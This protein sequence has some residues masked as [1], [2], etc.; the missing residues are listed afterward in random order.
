MILPSVQIFSSDWKVLFFKTCSAYSITTTEA[1]KHCPWRLLFDVALAA[2]SSSFIHQLTECWYL[3]RREIVSDPPQ[4]FSRTIFRQAT[5]SLVVWKLHGSVHNVDGGNHYVGGK[6]FM[7]WNWKLLQSLIPH[8]VLFV[9]RHGAVVKFF[10]DCV[11]SDVYTIK[12]FLMNRKI[13]SGDSIDSK[14]TRL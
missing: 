13:Q 5:Y 7:K 2:K 14:Y 10:P 1:E 11:I 9:G 12:R 4:C 8:F 3:S 6:I